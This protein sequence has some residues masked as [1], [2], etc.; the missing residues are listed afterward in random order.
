M[1]LNTIKR[2]ALV[3][4]IAAA[5]LATAVGSVQAA[6]PFETPAGVSENHPEAVWEYLP[7]NPWDHTVV[8]VHVRDGIQQPGGEAQLDDLIG[9]VD[10]YVAGRTRFLVDAVVTLEGS[11][12]G[13]YYTPFGFM[14]DK[15]WNLPSLAYPTEFGPVADGLNA[16]NALC[17]TQ[18]QTTCEVILVTYQAPTDPNHRRHAIAE[19][20]KLQTA[21][22]GS[23][24]LHT[25]AVGT[26]GS[27][28]PDH[29][30]FS[31]LVGALGNHSWANPGDVSLGA[32]YMIESGFW[33]ITDY[34]LDSEPVEGLCEVYDPDG[35]CYEGSDG[36]IIYDDTQQPPDTP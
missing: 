23:A 9:N 28:D 26:T 7:P 21:G 30:E 16:A 12:G 32:S 22:A 1:S 36:D 18:P 8:I 4:L 13:G 2:L 5:L 35:N 10:D 27:P 15:P 34:G 19:A 11:G 17:Q 33:A 20:M 14:G 29:V 6:A 3:P 24:R 31:R 25:I